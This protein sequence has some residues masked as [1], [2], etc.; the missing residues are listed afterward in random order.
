MARRRQGLGDY[1]RDFFTNW[2]EYE[3]PVATKVWLTALNRTR[4][5]ARTVGPPFTG[6]CGNHGQPGC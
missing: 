5:L 1:V 3:G 2:N 4:A 6:C